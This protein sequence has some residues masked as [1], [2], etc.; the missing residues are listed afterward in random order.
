MTDPLLF[1][2]PKRTYLDWLRGANPVTLERAERVRLRD[3]AR[4][5]E[6]H[7]EDAAVLDTL[8]G[9]V[10]RLRSARTTNG[11]HPRLKETPFLVIDAWLGRLHGIEPAI[12][13]GKLSVPILL[14]PEWVS[15]DTETEFVVL[16][17]RGPSVLAQA[18]RDGDGMAESSPGT[19]P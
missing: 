19:P 13:Q 15:L 12:S 18:C 8:V 16:G 10:V 6:E 11:G 2:I 9:K 4:W 5:R 1:R 17:R 7:P 14:R 3:A